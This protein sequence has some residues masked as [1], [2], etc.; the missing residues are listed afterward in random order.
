MSQVTRLRR[1]LAAEI[2]VPSSPRYAEISPSDVAG[3]EQV[4]GYKPM[5]DSDGRRLAP[6]AFVNKMIVEDLPAWYES[7][8]FEGLYQAG[9][10]FEATRQFRLGEKIS[11]T[12]ALGGVEEKT[13]SSGPV[14][15]ISAE[16]RFT[17]EDGKHIMTVCR[18]R[19]LVLRQSRWA[20][21]DT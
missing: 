18:V 15:L 14:W 21:P 4:T 19:A 8:G 12:V 17:D 9:E 16:Y 5:Y 2:G 13:G 20:T 10:Q 6:L 7:L 3:F 11:W 1:Q